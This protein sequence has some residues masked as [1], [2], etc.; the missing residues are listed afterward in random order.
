MWTSEEVNER[1]GEERLRLQ[2]R[3]EVRKE[4]SA[5]GSLAKDHGDHGKLST[6]Y[7]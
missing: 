6:R 5:D 7:S 3:A 1:D 2:T 4:L